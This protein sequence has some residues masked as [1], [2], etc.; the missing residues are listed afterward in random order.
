MFLL[1][2]GCVFFSN[3]LQ[4]SSLVNIRCILQP[5]F[6]AHAGINWQGAL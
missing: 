1:S 3:Y 4:P 2:N 6:L 5:L